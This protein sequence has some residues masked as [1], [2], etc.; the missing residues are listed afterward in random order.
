MSKK[1][2]PMTYSRKEYLVIGSKEMWLA[3]QRAKTKERIRKE[4]I[5]AKQENLTYV[6]GHYRNIK[7]KRIYIKPYIRKIKR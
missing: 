3:E 2:K 4:R 5:K 1:Y 6:K 7:E